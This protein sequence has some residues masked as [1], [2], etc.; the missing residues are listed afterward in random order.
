MSATMSPLFW[1]REFY[2][3]VTA[4]VING[5]AMGTL[6]V[7]VTI[8]IA[9]IISECIK[10]C[11]PNYIITPAFISFLMY[12]LITSF[13]LIFYPILTVV[14][15]NFTVFTSIVTALITMLIHTAEAYDID[16]NHPS[17]VI[18]KGGCMII[19]L[20]L[21]TFSSCMVRYYLII[22]VLSSS[23]LLVTICVT[24]PILIAL[25]IGCLF[26]W[27]VI[28]IDIHNNIVKKNL[29]L[30]FRL[31]QCIK[32]LFRKKETISHTV[33]VEANTNTGYKGE[34]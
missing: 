14:E 11:K 34:E 17:Y 30:R 20:V 33:L 13:A 25:V 9:L 18:R 19:N 31:P 23:A 8:G 26:S 2:N 5:L 27:I 28:G 12:S 29:S 21:A 10:K 24:S 1:E 15:C 22:D 6:L 4:Y 32:N 7:L 3:T 16:E